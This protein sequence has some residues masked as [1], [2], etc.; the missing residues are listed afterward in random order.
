MNNRDFAIACNKFFY[1]AM[2]YKYATVEVTDF[3][4][5]RETYAPQFINAFPID[6][7]LHLIGKFNSAFDAHGSYGA[8]MSF[9]AD[10]DGKNRMRFLSWVNDNFDESGEFGI[11]LNT[12]WNSENK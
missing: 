11:N 12:E 3:E 5:K 2:N 1:Y 4:G 6:V 9:Y 8:I 7:R 10:L